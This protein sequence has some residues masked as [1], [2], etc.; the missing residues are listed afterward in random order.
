MTRLTVSKVSRTA[1]AAVLATAAATAA[2][3]AA[4]P[5]AWKVDTARSR[6][7]VNVAPAGVL[8]GSLHEHHFHPSSWE[9]SIAF[10]SQS[11]EKVLLDVKIDATSLRDDQPKLSAKDI[12]KVEGQAR[13]D[14]ILDAAKYPEIRFTA[15]RAEVE[16]WPSG[17]EGDFKG[18]L[19]GTLT[20]HGR[21]KPLKIPLEGRVGPDRLE[22]AASVT[23]KQTEFG[24]EPY[25]T[26]LGAIA[27]KDEVIVEIHIVATP[28]P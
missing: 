28:A 23:F 21:S 16:K 10:D 17:G 5:R 20:L 12:A 13:S 27:V 1:V 11:L 24:I 7:T 8:S 9:C 2:A 26:L 6:I 3:R 4:E 14:R 19:A 25:K 18:T 15:D 22:A